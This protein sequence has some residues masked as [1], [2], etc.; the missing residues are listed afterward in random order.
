MSVCYYGLAIQSVPVPP[1]GM[2]REDWG[3]NQQRTVVLTSHRVVIV[4]LLSIADNLEAVLTAIKPVFL[5][6]GL[7]L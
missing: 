1:R 6:L 2:S 7:P 3:H 4:A 5:P